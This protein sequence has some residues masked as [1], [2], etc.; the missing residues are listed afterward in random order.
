MGLM[1]Q[2][3]PKG[4]VLPYLAGSNHGSNGVSS[5]AAQACSRSFCSCRASSCSCLR[6]A[7]TAAWLGPFFIQ[8]LSMGG[9]FSTLLQ[10]S[11]KYHA[12]QKLHPGHRDAAATAKRNKPRAPAW[13]WLIKPSP[14]GRRVRY[15]GLKPKPPP[16]Q[17]NVAQRWFSSQ[18]LVVLSRM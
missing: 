18:S 11:P 13:G 14:M 17:A 2:N 5:L 8:D 6:L 4:T 7:A 12:S 10:T 1:P 16:V 15:M 9:L 3:K